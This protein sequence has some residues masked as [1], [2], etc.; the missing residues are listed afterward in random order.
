[1]M[2]IF[3]SIE[4]ECFLRISHKELFWCATMTHM[5]QCVMIAGTLLRPLSSVDNLVIQMVSFP[6]CCIE[7]LL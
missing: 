7:L 3:C 6:K 2:V 4:M 1:M 5:A